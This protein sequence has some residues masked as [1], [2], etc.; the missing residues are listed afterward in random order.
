MFRWEQCMMVKWVKLYL[1]FTMWHFKKK[2]GV[3]RAGVV[4]LLT[5]FRRDD[6]CR[7]PRGPNPTFQPH[8]CCLWKWSSP[9]P[10][11]NK[12]ALALAHWKRFSHSFWILIMYIWI[13]KKNNLKKIKKFPKIFEFFQ[14]IFSRGRGG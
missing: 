14:C 1:T 6:Y 9:G 4:W 11:E 13:N 12:K 10:L 8:P 5:T 2:V 3:G 7:A